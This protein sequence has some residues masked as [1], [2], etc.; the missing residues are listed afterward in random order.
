MLVGVEFV[1]V[2]AAGAGVVWVSKARCGR[3]VRELA[4]FVLLRSTLLLLLREKK[5]R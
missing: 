4:D 2:C 3:N 1:E 5:L